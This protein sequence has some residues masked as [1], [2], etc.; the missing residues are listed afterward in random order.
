MGNNRK[1]KKEAILTRKEAVQVFKI[2]KMDLAFFERS[3]KIPWS[4]NKH[5]YT[6]HEF[7]R[8]SNRIRDFYGDYHS[9]LAPL[10]S[11]I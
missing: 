7:Q 2:P 9:R 10:K 11:H 6:L 8:L 3:A 5:G 4:Q 1:R